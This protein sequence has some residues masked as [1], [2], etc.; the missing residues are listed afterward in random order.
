MKLAAL[1]VDLDEIPCYHAIHGLPMPDG[2]SA[3]AVYA[4]AVAR[5]RELLATLEAPCTFFVIGRDMDH[6]VAREGARS[7]AADGHELANHS[8]HGE[9]LFSV[10]GLGSQ[11]AALALAPCPGEHVLDA[12]CGLGTKTLHLAELM[13]RRGT[14]VAADASADRLA[15]HDDLVL[16]GALAVPEL[17]LTR[18][19][20]DLTADCPGVDERQYDAVLLDAPCT[21]LG[22]LGRHPELRWTS[23]YEDITASAAR[24]R[25]LLARCLA[26]VRPGGRLVYAVCSLEPE[27][28][29][30]LVRTFDATLE[31]EQMWTPEGED[32]DGF[33]LARLRPAPR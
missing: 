27:E 9:G 12:C 24:Q 31:F 23:R 33:Y 21:G 4:R 2:E 30:Q 10:Q 26:R 32:T 18:V 28:G 25:E 1:S 17:A 20:G 8:L 14:L 29:P 6:D 15:A 22:N 11:Q 3:H 5:Y 13:Q 7:L 19:R 16:R